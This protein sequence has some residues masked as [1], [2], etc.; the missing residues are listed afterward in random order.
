MIKHVTDAGKENGIGVFMCGEMAGDPFNV[1]IL[2]G[3]GIDELSMN[4]QSIPAV[5]NMIRSLRVEDAKLLVREALGQ[6][7]T[8]DVIKLVE[9]SFGETLGR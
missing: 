4:P 2:L 7:T 5:K 6:T 8:L 1:P 3:L 9:A